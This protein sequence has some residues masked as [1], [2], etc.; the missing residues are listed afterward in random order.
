MTEQNSNTGHW[1][2][3]LV[4]MGATTNHDNRP[5]F[6]PAIEETR[7]ARDGGILADLS[8]LSVLK[9]SGDDAVSFLQ[10]QLTNDIKKINNENAQL[11][12]YC[13]AKGR[14]LALFLIYRREDA[15]YILVEKELADLLQKKLTMYILRSKVT[16]ERMIDQI[17]IGISGQTAAKDLAKQFKSLSTESYSV[18]STELVSIICL[19]G[20][21]PRYVVI[22]NFE[23]IKTIWQDLGTKYKQAGH[24]AWYWL[25]IMSGIP[26]LKAVN[27]E[28]F[29][30]Q[31]TNFEIINGVS[32]KKGCYPGQEIVARMQYLGK[33]KQRMYHLKYPGEKPPKA[34]DRI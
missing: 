9:V 20:Y 24:H 8:G 15:I 4:S 17:V 26:V 11:S 23:T 21:A 31:M 12:A 13:T 28:A 6:A 10:S 16:I 1:D 33:L 3:F 5:C 7:M 30:P 27:S 19:N 22:G 29:V 18:C 2:K 25:D 34:G 32:F 14:M